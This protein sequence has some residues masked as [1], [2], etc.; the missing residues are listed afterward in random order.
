MENIKKYNSSLG[1]FV[2]LPKGT[3]AIKADR[4]LLSRFELDDEFYDLVIYAS[5]KD[6]G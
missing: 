3:K 4:L 1:G 6:D 5:L 2:L